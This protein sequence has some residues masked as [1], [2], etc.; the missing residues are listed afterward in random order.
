[1]RQPSRT[2]LAAVAV[3]AL[4]ATAGCLADPIGA[5][6]HPTNATDATTTTDAT[7]RT[8]NDDHRSGTP[9]STTGTTE[10]NDVRVWDADSD[11]APDLAAS[12]PDPVECNGGWVSYWGTGNP[13]MLWSEDGQL[14]VGWT[15]PANQSTLF[16]GFENETAV[17]YDHVE[18]AESVTADGAG[19]PVDDDGTGRYAVAMMLD[20]NGN[21][22]YDPGTDRPCSDDDG[23]IETTGW[24]WVDWDAED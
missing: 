18:Y 10:Y 22:E 9:G 2:T 17:G 16:V 24:L 7:E 19:V 1:M 21:G 20:V 3:L 15:V 14:R 13:G 11:D 6:T 5:G 8:T 4:V 12:L 23:G